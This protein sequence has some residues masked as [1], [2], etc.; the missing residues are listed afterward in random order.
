MP[1]SWASILAVG[2]VALAIAGATV[3]FVALVCLAALLFQVLLD[4]Y[5]AAQS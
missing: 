5:M 4:I 1:T 2:A 3:A